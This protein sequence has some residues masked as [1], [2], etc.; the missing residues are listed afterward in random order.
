M[1]SADYAKATTLQVDQWLHNIATKPSYAYKTTNWYKALKAL[2]AEAKTP[3]PPPTPPPGPDPLAPYRKLLF[4]AQSP[5]DAL[6][7]GPG[8]TVLFTADPAYDSWATKSAADQMR[9][10]GQ[11][12]GVWYVPTEVTEARADEVAARLGTTFILGQCETSGQFDASVVQGCKAMVGNLSALE[13]PQLAL[14]ALGVRIVIN[15]TYYGCNPGMQPDWRNA[16]KGVAGNCLA[17]YHD[18]QCQRIPLSEQIANGWYVHGRDSLY[19]PGLTGE[20]YAVLRAL[21]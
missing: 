18:S 17:C 3:A 6:Q 19:G 16:N 11:Q 21:K 10:A 13:P 14:V 7:A 15:E 2:E 1:T 4:M 12:V 8:W 5:L 9:A 20:D